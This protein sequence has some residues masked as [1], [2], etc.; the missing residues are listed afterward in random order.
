MN[1]ADAPSSA[2]DLLRWN[3]SFRAL[4]LSRTTSFI[5]DALGTI[6]ILLY[7][8]DNE[9]TGVAVA[10]LFLAVDFA[11]SLVSPLT[12]T[13][14]DRVDRKR[15]MI[16]CDLAQAVIIVAIAL[17]GMPLSLL[18]VLVAVRSTL[19]SL[20]QPA[21]RSSVPDLVNER[22][23]ETANAVIGFGT[24]GFDLLGPLL[25]AALL[26]LIGIRGMLIVD[27]ATFL[28]S[29]L[30]LMRLPELSPVHIEEGRVTFLRDAGDGL[31]FLWQLPAL[32]MLTVGFCAVVALNG[33]DDVALVFLAQGVLDGTDSQ[34]SLL[35]GGAGMGLLIGFL[36]LARFASR[37]PV[38]TLIGAGF[39]ISSLGN[40]MTGLSV[41]VWMAFAMQAVRGIG[42]S[43]IEVSVQTFV[44]RTV[45]KGMQGRAF[46]NLFGA[47]GLSAGLA[48][49][50]GGPL[51]DLTGP[52]VVLAV[53]GFAGAV[54]ALVLA[55]RLTHV[56]RPTSEAQS[57]S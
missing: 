9:A 44:Q 6:A 39:F 42:I 52:R 49:A 26:P 11:P 40:A 31:R 34:T 36:T 5:G 29:A 27:A 56:I 32:R 23:L 46:A 37:F 47:V 35:Y 25:G 54:V 30:L 10:I 1:A 4:W 28:V 22:E 43:L 48:Y 2:V 12:G 13:L 33:V 50:I 17:V 18:L 57:V 16:S 15:L 45:P 24:H 7:V 51:L 53:G 14:S 3:A 41:T 38:V 19:G 55:R 8:F 21:S 20:F